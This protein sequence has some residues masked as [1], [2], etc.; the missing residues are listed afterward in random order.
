MK[1]HSISRR[2]Q[3]EMVIDITRLLNRRMQARLPTGV[4][5]VSLEYVRYFGGRSTAL[6]R[7]YGQWIELN[8]RSSERI[9][10]ALLSPDEHIKTLARKVVSRAFPCSIG[11]HFSSSQYLFNTGHSGLENIQYTHRLQRSGL[12]PLFFVHDLIPITHPEYCRPGESERH[13]ARINTMLKTGHGIIANSAATLNDLTAY[14]QTHGL[15][16]PPTTVALL[17]PAQFPKPVTNIPLNKPY[18]VMLGTVESRKNH[19][20]MLQLWRQLIEQFGD[21]A[22]RLVIIGQR[23]WECENV[24][25]LLERCEVLKGFVFEYSSCSDSELVSWLH[26]AQALLFPS[27]AEGYGMPLMEALSIG[28]PVIASDLPAFREI[29]GDIPAYVDPLDGRR[30]RELIIEYAKPQSQER[31]NQCQRMV[32]FSA[33]TWTAHFEQVEAFM[34]RF[35]FAPY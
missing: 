28:L 3:S 18:F 25:D 1:F 16:L 22:P 15:P 30:W 4:D 5:R 17:A 2:A 20:L 24:V 26:H 11:R 19:W 9:F 14:A 12:K 23:G 35:S 13:R 8:R 10:D 21:A 33:P 27:F 32:G 31:L 29:S 34:D 7:F 6:V